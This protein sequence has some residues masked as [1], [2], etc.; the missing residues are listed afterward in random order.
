MIHLALFQPEIPQN[1]GTLIRYAA[2]M[3]ISLHIIEPCGFIMTEKNL[4]RA[5]MDYIELAVLHRHASWEGFCLSTHNHRKILIDADGS[6]DFHKFQ[7][8]ENDVLILGQESR[9]FPE[10]IHRQIST[11]VKIPMQ[12]GRRSLNVAIAGAIVATEAL[13][14]L[15]EL[16]LS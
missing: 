1:T 6:N 11:S 14:Q 16:P 15:G 8:L 10:D 7:F 12:E 2:C 4:L 5:G 13:R 9:G 3:G